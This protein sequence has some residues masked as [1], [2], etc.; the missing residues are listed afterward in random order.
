MTTLCFSVMFK[1][2]D[3]MIQ[4]VRFPRDLVSHGS[5]WAEGGVRA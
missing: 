2:C 1:S 3:K 4:V 5:G